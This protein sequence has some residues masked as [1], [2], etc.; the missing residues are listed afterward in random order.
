M[1]L[2]KYNETKFNKKFS[3]FGIINASDYHCSIKLSQK[4]CNSIY[5][6]SI[7]EAFHQI[8]SN[9]SFKIFD[10]KYSVDFEK[11]IE[12]KGLFGGK[13]QDTIHESENFSFNKSLNFDLN[14]QN[15]NIKNFHNGYFKK[16]KY[17]DKSY[18]N[19]AKK[20]H[21]FNFFFIDG[22]FDSKT[23][24]GTGKIE[25]IIDYFK[26]KP[27][28]DIR[29]E[30]R[31]SRGEKKRILLGSKF[32]RL[33]SYGHPKQNLFLLVFKIQNQQLELHN[34]IFH[35]KYE[36]DRYPEISFSGE[37]VY[38]K[39]YDSYKYEYIKSN[40]YVTAEIKSFKSKVSDEILKIS[41]DKK[42]QKQF[43]NLSNKIIRDKIAEINNAETSRKET[44]QK[45]KDSFFLEFDQNDN[46][47]IDIL[48][49]K[50][51]EDF[52]KR[53]QKAIVAV[54]RKLIQDFVKLSKFLRDK[55]A[56]LVKVF[57]LI[58]DAKTNSSI[59]EFKE[60]F[61]VQHY[62][63]AVS[64][65]EAYRMLLA[66]IQ[67]DMITFYEIHDEFE[68]M[69]AFEA[70]WQKDLNTMRKDLSDIKELNE[71][72]VK[73]L[74]KISY[75]IFTME[76]TMIKG[77]NMINS[78][79]TEGFNALNDNL[80]AINQNIKIMN[81]SLTNE[82]KGINNKLWWNNLFQTVQIYQNRRRYNQL[83]KLIK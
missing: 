67:D 40:K 43:V 78:T 28:N 14:F 23:F 74:L 65:F 5:Y 62:S 17:D 37:K 58:R 12:N 18:I 30:F 60:T 13:K 82:L 20:Q 8:Y 31:D 6:D 4:K 19:Q 27:I 54:D 34:M 49:E 48:E 7:F 1:Q 69:R 32:S 10:I 2:V 21:M 68:S 57:S 16:I 59:K 22:L 50:G 70:Q 73:T 56:N 9:Y 66:L 63:Y 42:L 29:S 44:L 47:K 24:I 83:N 52:L 80:S 64:L 76:R 71:V 61:E 45:S 39:E 46:G 41:N 25:D 75:Q 72:T 55:Q 15:N 36:L 38:L 77:F 51:F 11:G 26:M 53:N 81:K 35:F 3:D 33:S 79:L